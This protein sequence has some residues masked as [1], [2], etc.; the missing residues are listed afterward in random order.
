MN[1]PTTTT[2][3]E[4]AAPTV[5]GTSH[6][7]S[8]SAERSGRPARPVSA[9]DRGRASVTARQAARVAAATLLVMVTAAALARV[10]DRPVALLLAIAA[11]PAAAV[12]LIGPARALPRVIVHVVVAAVTVAVA[13]VVAG[14]RSPG[15]VGTGI[16]RGWSLAVSTDWPSPLRS[17]L[18]AGAAFTVC[19]V[20]AASVEFARSQ[21]WRAVTLV[22]S[23]V[24]G[25]L[26]VGLAAPAG[27]PPALGLVTWLLVAGAVL[28]LGDAG[29]AHAPAREELRGEG[30]AVLS[31][32]GVTVV[33]GLVVALVAMGG[34]VDPRAG[35]RN[36]IVSADEVNPLARVAA[37]RALSPPQVRFEIRPA[38]GVTPATAATRWRTRVLDE[39]DGVTWTTAATVRPVSADHIT[40]PSGPIGEYVVTASAPTQWLP[41]GGIPVALDHEAS[42]DRDRS[43]L[44]LD[45]PL[46]AGSQVRLDTTP[47]PRPGDVPTRATS[48]RSSDP[49]A[50]QLG[51][52]ALSFAGDATTTIDQLDAIAS[53][54]RTT[55]RLSPNVAASAN[56]AVVRSLLERHDPGTPE[57][58]V[59]AF[60]LLTRAL[61][62]TARI[63]VGYEVVAGAPTLTTADASAWP[64][65]WFDDIGWVA[66]DVVPTTEPT[67]DP[68]VQLPVAG[69]PTAIPSQ[70]PVTQPPPSA[71]DEQPVPAPAGTGWSPLAKLLLVIGIALGVLVT[72]AMFVG[73]AVLMVKRRRRRRRLSTIDP[74]RRV[75]GAW[76]EATD[77]LVDLGAEFTS[78]DTNGEIAAAG[79]RIIGF[80]GRTVLVD[81]AG[82]ANE[83]SHGIRRADGVVAAH[84]VRLLGQ[85]EQILG[86]SAGRT[87]RL[88]R[89]LSLRSLLRRTSSPVR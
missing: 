18:I 4:A 56:I 82:L 87:R 6:P 5:V 35:R 7:A 52:L 40:T 23:L 36:P 68:E 26:A 58:F 75:L 43:V 46:P 13:L 66:F 1:A 61:G 45:P 22:P 83:A 17:E 50:A 49:E 67:G 33:A 44:L 65:V 31:L 41:I 19:V 3:N 64:E 14:G 81:L 55:Y 63:A 84:A 79:S 88:R 71:P 53:M 59:E 37:D 72:V 25:V 15:Q 24:L 9:S 38:I 32:L 10:Y 57:Q 21:R 16:W 78:S 51:A 77:R 8:P 80:R 39:Y 85:L 34:R 11:L 42:S 89:R 74:Q 2:T 69:T 29:V 62:A 86:E 47:S 76:A 60:V 20:A 73:G 54:L 70:P 48:R 30:R 28:G 27:P 12:G